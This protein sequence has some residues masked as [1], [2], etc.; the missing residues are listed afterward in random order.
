MQNR[1]FIIACGFA[2]CVCTL[3]ASSALNAETLAIES[4][5]KIDLHSHFYADI[6][7]L[8]ALMERLNFRSVIIC[9]GNDNDAGLAD[10][11][12]HAMA[13]RARYPHRFAV[14]STWNA[15]AWNAPDF[16][17]RSIAW[18][19][20]TFDEGACMVKIWKNVGMEFKREDGSYVMPDDPIFAPIYRH[21]A[22]R[23]IP[24]IAHL[25]DPVAAWRPLDPESVHYGYYSRN[26][27]WHLYGKE[28]VPSYDDIIAARDHILEQNPDLVFIGA[29]IG[30]MAHDLNEVAKRLDRFPN[31]NVEIAAR[32]GD[33]SRKPAEEVRAFFVKYQDRIMYGSDLE[34]CFQDDSPE[35]RKKSVEGAEKH[36]LNTFQYYAGTGTAYIAHKDVECLALP[37]EVL[38]KFFFKNAL[39]LVPELRKC[40]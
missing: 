37:K 34:D 8:D 25:A 29:H 4:I 22:E 13:L 26:L 6:P 21:L 24:L 31:F 7:E 11:D 38:E 3:L 32:T 2:I 33:L 18:L 12:K 19:D 30:S 15:A 40:F 17:E 16:A 20:H 14:C 36:Y 5:P 10:W 35:A 28:G 1:H 23:R 27:E 39:R 9:L